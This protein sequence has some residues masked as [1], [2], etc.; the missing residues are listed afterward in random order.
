ML[1]APAGC[2]LCGVL[3]SERTARTSLVVFDASRTDGVAGGGERSETVFVHGL[4]AEP[5]V[6]A[7]HE[8]GL[9][10]LARLDQRER[11]AV[12]AVSALDLMLFAAFDWQ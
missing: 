8:G 6:E 1:G 9:R 7:L 3:V 11:R 4:V 5:G 10:W 12:T 2:K